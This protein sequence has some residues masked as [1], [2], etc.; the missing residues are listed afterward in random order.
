MPQDMKQSRGKLIADVCGGIMGILII[1]ILWMVNLSH[2]AT[3][4]PNKS[5]IYILACMYSMREM[6]STAASIQSQHKT[7]L[8]RALYIDLINTFQGALIPCMEF[9]L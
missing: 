9:V 5:K 7:V 3:S 2:I 8:S 4:I 1:V 6:R